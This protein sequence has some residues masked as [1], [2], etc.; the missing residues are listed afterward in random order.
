MALS[1]GHLSVTPLHLDLTD[2]RSLEETAP[3]RATLE[4]LVW[5]GAEVDTEVDGE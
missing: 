1:T 4:G 5:P 2:Y 3:V